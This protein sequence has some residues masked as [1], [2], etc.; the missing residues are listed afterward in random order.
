M[1]GFATILSDEDIAAVLSWLRGQA[2]APGWP[3][4]MRQVAVERAA[5]G[6]VGGEARQ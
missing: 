4:L 3:D 6:R 2:H 1:P 5:L